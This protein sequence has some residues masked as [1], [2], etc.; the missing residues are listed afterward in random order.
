MKFRDGLTKIVDNFG[1]ELRI[2]NTD[3]GFFVFQTYNKRVVVHDYE[4]KALAK[5]LKRTIKERKAA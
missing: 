3:E 1:D 4:A 5:L 2:E